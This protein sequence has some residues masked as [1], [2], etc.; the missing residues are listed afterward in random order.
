[1]LRLETAELISHDSGSLEKFLFGHWKV[2]LTR[3]EE[4]SSGSS[5]VQ[6]MEI[7]KEGF[8]VALLFGE[9]AEFSWQ[10]W[11]KTV[12][13]DKKPSPCLYDSSDTCQSFV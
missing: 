10:K 8:K 11:F 1:M 3:D 7:R 6:E 5:R 4:V 9:R 2:I 13:K 12:K